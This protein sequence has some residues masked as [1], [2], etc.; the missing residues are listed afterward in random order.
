V[1]HVSAGVF[2]LN[3]GIARVPAAPIP[4]ST[5][6]DSFLRMDTPAAASPPDA[7]RDAREV[8]AL[9][10]TGSAGIRRVLPVA[11]PLILGGALI[12]ALALANLALE[13]PELVTVAGI[14]ALLVAASFAEAFPV[15][16]E[17]AGSVSLTAV[18]IVATGV[19]YG[20]ELAVVVSFLTAAIIELIQKK[21]FVRLACNASIYSLSG[22]LAALLAHSLPHHDAVE[23]LLGEVLLGALG[24]YAVNMMLASSVIARFAAQPLRDVLV[25]NA[26]ENATPFAIMASVSLMLAVLWRASPFLMAALVGPLVAV[27]LYQRSVH[28]AMRAMRLALTDTQTGLGNKR[29]FEELLQRYLDRADSE[30][31]PVTLCLIDLDNFKGINDLFGHPVGDRVLAQVAAR[32]RRG[33][34]AFRLGGDEFALLLPGR[35]AEEGKAIAQTVTRRIAE[36]KYEHGGAVTVSAGVASYPQD[37]LDRAELVRVA[38]KA[39]YSAKGHGKARVHVYEPDTRVTPAPRPQ[40]LPGRVANL[41]QAASAAHAVV[42]RD[43]YIG[44]HS[45]NVAE[46]AARLGHRLGLDHDQVELVRVAGNLHDIGKLFVPEELLHKPGP[47][48]PAERIVVERHAEIGHKMLEALSIEPVATWVLRQHERWDGTGYPGRLAGEDI[49]LASRILFVADAYDTLTTDRVYRA[50]VSRL[51]ALAEL[52]RCAG[53]QFD[54]AVVAALHEEL[55]GTALELVL[56][57]TA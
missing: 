30:G 44:S 32:L 42:A 23:V 9:P 46:L 28:K 39:L 13:P 5:A 50:K 8:V 55:G 18:F 25:R 37:D 24:F 52:D 10:D 14:L 29:H 40:G 51:E 34:E 4:I 47:L 1:S 21:P 22:G 11:V 2:T 16:T 3:L 20:W 38:D 57:A 54:P 45:H 56:P 6:G 48:S 53:T 36:A 33:G 43:V 12:L 49:P 26:I 7:A 27:A 15:P 35:N 17:P 41:R 31:T 19:L